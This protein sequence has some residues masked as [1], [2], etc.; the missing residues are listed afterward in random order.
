MPKLTATS[1]AVQLL[2]QKFEKGEVQQSTDP[3]S[4][5]ESENIF[6]EHKLDNFRTCVNRLKRFYFDH[7]GEFVC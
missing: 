3:K 1:P 6:Q 4:I 5:W 2:Q 7:N